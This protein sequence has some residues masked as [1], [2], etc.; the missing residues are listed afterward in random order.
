MGDF[1]RS[2]QSLLRE[3]GERPAR[4][5]MG[6]MRGDPAFAA[7]VF[8]WLGEH[9]QWL[10][11]EAEAL[12][13]ELIT[14]M[15]ERIVGHPQEAEY[16]PLLTGR[17]SPQTADRLLAALAESIEMFDS[18]LGPDGRMLMPP[19]LSA[20]RGEANS[21][22]ALAETSAFLSRVGDLFRES[23]TR[24]LWQQAEEDARISELLIRHGIFPKAEEG[25]GLA[26]YE[27]GP[28]YSLPGPGRAPPEA[29][30][31]LGKS[32][33]LGTATL[34]LYLSFLT[35]DARPLAYYK[36]GSGAYWRTH[37]DPIEGIPYPSWLSLKL[38]NR[39]VRGDL[40]VVDP[41]QVRTVDVPEKEIRVT[42]ND[43]RGRLRRIPGR[44]GVS[45]TECHVF[46]DGERYAVVLLNRDASSARDVALA[47]PFAGARPAR[48]VVMTHPDP[49]AHNRFEANVVLREQAAPAMRSG[50]RISIPPASVMVWV[51]EDP[52][53]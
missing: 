16:T 50:A 19:L 8:A 4:Q 15:L 49:A 10:A 52:R 7:A 34:D 28:G 40:L 6:A 25:I 21:L 33:A 1:E 41:Q 43:G 9:P 13:R 37:N 23:F 35:L 14:E 32:L 27:G 45:W 5:L 18:D 2:S 42:S 12:G 26:V 38:F 44:E 39:E 24:P 48:M 3:A 17:L 47:F 20:A 22:A 29:D 11:E 31:N 53:P 36:F 51:T 46:R 30:E